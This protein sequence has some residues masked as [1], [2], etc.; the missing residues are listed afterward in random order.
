MSDNNKNK[1]SS[2]KTV[3]VSSDQSISTETDTNEPV[4]RTPGQFD[5]L[6][7]GVALVSDGYN[8][9]IIR[10]MNTVLAK[11]YPKQMTAEVKTRLSNSILIGDIFGMLLFGLCIDRFG[12][13]VGIYLTT[14]FLVLGIVIATAAHGVSVEGMFWMM[15]I[16]RGVAGVGAGGEYTVCTSQAVECADSTEAMRKRR[17]MLVAVA[18]NAAIISGFVASSIVSLIAIAAYRCVLHD[19]IWRICFGIGV[20]LPLGIFFFRLRLMDSTQY[21]KHAIQHKIPYKLAIKYYWKPLL[22]CCSAWFIYDAVVYPFNLLAPT[23]VAGFSNNQTMQES[24]GWSALINFFALP[25]AFIGSLLMD[26]IGRRQTYALG[27][28]IVCVFGFVIGGTMYPLNSPSAFPAFVTL[29]GLFQTFC[30]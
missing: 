13:R 1:M 21:K 25:G 10:Y 27:W 4:P 18:T 3:A 30:R 11:L 8:I 20:I 15:V 7:Q 22:G 24:I 5:V 6:V 14:L 29:Y 9:Q 12:R 28:S 19:G 23:L 2:D 26:R 17:G 16:G